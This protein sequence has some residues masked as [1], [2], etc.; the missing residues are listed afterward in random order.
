M[1]NACF[2]WLKASLV[3][4][5]RKIGFPIALISEERVKISDLSFFNSLHL[6]ES[7]IISLALPSTL[8]ISLLLVLNAFGAKSDN[9]VIFNIEI[10]DVGILLKFQM[11]RQ[12]KLAK[13]K[14][15][16]CHILTLV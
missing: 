8:T 11:K 9:P 13:L 7:L 3:Q 1:I 2:K 4:R 14:T 6:D 16:K 5:V 12:W 10:S 15:P